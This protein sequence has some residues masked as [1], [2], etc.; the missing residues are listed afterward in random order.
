AEIRTVELTVD[1]TAVVTW[2]DALTRLLGEH[3]TN[4]AYSSLRNRIV[5][6]GASFDV[7]KIADAK[8]G[9]RVV[10]ALARIDATL[11]Y[12]SVLGDCW[13]IK[14]SD[15]RAITGVCKAARTPFE[16]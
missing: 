7:L 1:G 15:E 6:A 9:A 14:A 16:N 13:T 11:C 5:R 4:V 8:V 2:D 10:K 12:C 3:V